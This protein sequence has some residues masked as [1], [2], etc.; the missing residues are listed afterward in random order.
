MPNF[1]EQDLHVVGAKADIDRF[2]RAGVTRDPET[3]SGEVLDFLKL[4]PL[5]RREKRDTYLPPKE[6]FRA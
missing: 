4:C 3:G 6:D 1:V 5:G 2:M